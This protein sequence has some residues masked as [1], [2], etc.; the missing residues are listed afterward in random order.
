MGVAEGNRLHQPWERRVPGRLVGPAGRERGEELV[1]LLGD[2][3]LEVRLRLLQRLQLVRLTD[4][5]GDERVAAQR[6][7]RIAR[8]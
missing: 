3:D 7:G 4:A 2:L 8:A 1:E 5:A 6:P